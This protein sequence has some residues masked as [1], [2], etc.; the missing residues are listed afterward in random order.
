MTRPLLRT[1]LR[2]HIIKCKTRSSRRANLLFSFHFVTIFRTVPLFEWQFILGKQALSSS[3]PV[4][5]ISFRK[6]MQLSVFSGQRQSTSWTRLGAIATRRSNRNMEGRDQ[7]AR[8]RHE[9]Q[10]WAF[11]CIV[12][13]AAINEDGLEPVT[14]LVPCF[15]TDISKYAIFLN[16]KRYCM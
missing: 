9:H 7:D 12:E 6:L 10:S 1:D 3:L 15:S 2:E 11:S 14:T 5:V 8:V 4:P 16:T 13:R